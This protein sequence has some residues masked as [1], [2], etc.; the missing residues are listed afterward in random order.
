[1]F[2]DNPDRNGR[3]ANAAKAEKL[4]IGLCPIRGGHFDAQALLPGSPA[5]ILCAGSPCLPHL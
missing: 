4:R 5:F 3:T 1:M 2:I